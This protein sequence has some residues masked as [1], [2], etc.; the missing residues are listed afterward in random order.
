[1]DIPGNSI[2]TTNMRFSFSF[3][4]LVRLCHHTM[5]MQIELETAFHRFSTQGRGVSAS[6]PQRIL[7]GIFGVC[8]GAFRNAARARCWTASLSQVATPRVE[9]PS[10][11]RYLFLA[12]IAIFS[13]DI[14][15]K[16]RTGLPPIVPG[17]RPSSR[18]VR[19]SGGGG[20]QVRVCGAGWDSNSNGPRTAAPGAW[21]QI[22]P[23]FF[24]EGI[25]WGAGADRWNASRSF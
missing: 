24:F 4:G 9:T 3:V 25:A 19:R 18:T 23:T 20:G 11:S 12:R 17:P 1:M 5:I 14:D 2:V 22:T 10:P 16:P 7:L 21:V 8:T 15:Q 6:E 13:K